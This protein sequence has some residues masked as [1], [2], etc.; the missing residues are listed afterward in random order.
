MAAIIASVAP[1]ETVTSASASTS[2]PHA[3][4]CLRAI[5]SRSGAA[6]HVVAY[7]LCPSRSAWAAASTMRGSGSKSGKP[8]AK[9]TALSGP[10]S[11]RLR[12]VISRMTDSVKLCAFSDWRIAPRLVSGIG[13]LQVKIRA[14]AREAPHRALEAALPPAADVA[15]PTRLGEE[16]EDVRA[17]E[18]AHH[19]PAADHRH[20]ADA[21][22]DEEP[23]RLVDAR[24]L[25]DRDH[26]RAHD[27]ARRLA[28]LGEH[29]GLGHDADDVALVADD[30]RAR[31]V[32]G[33][34]RA[35]DLFDR[36][37]LAE[38]DHVARHHVFDRYHVEWP[39]LA[40]RRDRAASAAGAKEGVA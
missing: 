30:R 9:L 35:R 22:A 15:G 10:C 17:A 6:P 11:A 37:V 31:D 5:A 27:V 2:R 4:D 34:E 3:A 7:W 12:R 18:Q 28:A 8:W 16:V 14:G 19:L 39:A 1:Q 21:L 36:S 38:R 32:L 20:A 29:V 13:S 23:C 26:A 33:A 25:G 40:G 24:L